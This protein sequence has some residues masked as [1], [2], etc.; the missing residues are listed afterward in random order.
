MT[1]VVLSGLIVFLRTLTFIVYS[2]LVVTVFLRNDT[3][4]YS[5]LEVFL[6]VFVTD[7]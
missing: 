6:F 1:L 5:G 4:V 7:T 2:G 3:L